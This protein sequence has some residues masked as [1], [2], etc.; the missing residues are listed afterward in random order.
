M[1][2]P[3][4]IVVFSGGRGTKA[5]QESLSGIDN[6][7]VTYLI[8][9]YDSGLSTGEVRRLIPGMLGPSDFRKALSGISVSYRTEHA[10][11]LSSVFEFRLPL[12]YS[13][14]NLHFHRLGAYGDCLKYI[15]EVDPKLP[16]T[17]ALDLVEKITKFATYA[18]ENPQAGFDPCDLALGNAYFGGAFLET[19]SFNE[20]LDCAKNYLRF[21]K[22]LTFSTSP[23]ETTCG[24]LFQLLIQTFA[25]RRGT[26]SPWHHLRPSMRCF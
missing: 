10:A 11:S 20:A 22:M 18:H 7:R 3:A 14:A 26:L 4:E 9:G 2:K 24:W 5:V 23:K 17:L 15:N 21:P 1:T 13:E 19:S 12:D 6:V 8:N 25:L 16:L